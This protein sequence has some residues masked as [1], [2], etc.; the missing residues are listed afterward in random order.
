MKSRRRQPSRK[1]QPNTAMIQLT[2]D[3]HEAEMAELNAKLE[4]TSKMMQQANA[5]LDTREAEA[6]FSNFVD[7]I[8]RIAAIEQHA[9]NQSLSDVI[10]YVNEPAATPV[11]VTKPVAPVMDSTPAPVPPPKSLTVPVMTQVTQGHLFGET[12]AE[13]IKSKKRKTTNTNQRRRR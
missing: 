4:E 3:Q 6:R 12:L 13:R 2:L 10:Q 1:R 7:E 8:C 5:L 11:A 9:N